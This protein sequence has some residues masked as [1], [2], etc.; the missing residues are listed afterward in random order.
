MPLEYQDPEEKKGKKWTRE[1]VIVAL[2]LYRSIPYAKVDDSNPEVQKIAEIIGRTVGS[3][4]KKLMNIVRFDPELQAKGIKGLPKGGKMDGIVWYEFLNDWD[5]LA[6]E[7]ARLIEEFRN[8]RTGTIET[9]SSELDIAYF[10][11]GED[12]MRLAKTRVYQDFFRAAVLSAYQNTCCITGIAT[13]ELNNASH[14]IP[15]SK[16]ETCRTNPS[17]G[18]CLNTLHDRAFDLGLIT[19]LPDLTVRISK[20]LKEIKDNKAIQQYFLSYEGH[21]ITEPHRYLPERKFLEYHNDV[22]FEKKERD[23]NPIV[24]LKLPF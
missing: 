16:D 21:H 12:K 22:I 18:L 7:S 8:R 24:A 10:P 20:E 1:E 19:V 2:R 13:R 14:I 17:N 5:G 6:T 3:V 4:A 23:L 9:V 11:K 15:W